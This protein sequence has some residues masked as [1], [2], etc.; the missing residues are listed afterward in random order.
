MDLA[1]FVPKL[2]MRS[3]TAKS[4]RSQTDVPK[5]AT[6]TAEAEELRDLVRLL[7]KQSAREF[8]RILEDGRVELECL[9]E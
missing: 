3:R 4:D 1:V 2:G 7:A 5:V 6:S 8:I 9:E